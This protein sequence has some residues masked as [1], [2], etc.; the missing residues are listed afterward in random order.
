[1][2]CR[3]ERFAERFSSGGHRIERCLACGLVQLHPLPSPEV[4][5][6]L[7]GDHYYA[8]DGGT[9]YRD[10][11]AHEPGHRATFEAD[12]RRME[13]FFPAGRS[14]RVLDVGCGPGVFVTAALAAGHDAYGVDLVAS[15]V[16]H[17]QRR[18]PGRV[19]LG[20][21]EAAADLGGTPF[22]VV[23]ASHVIEHLAE[24]LAFTARCRE[25]LGPGGLLVCVTPNVR[26]WLARLSGRRWVS[27]KIPE[28]LAY[29]DPDTIRRL[30]TT[31]G[32]ETLAVDPAYE[33]HTVAFLAE[34]VRSLVRP[35]D[36]V[37]PPVERAPWLRD[38]VVRVTS[39]SLRAIARA[40]R[41]AS[42]P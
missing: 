16:E 5:A 35:L 23:F 10:Y 9:G 27:F 42:Q 28:H 32:F 2:L 22:D 33:H 6:A 3:G 14:L 1:M 29:Y 38:R 40:R 41:P 15:A 34:R 13:G 19:A 18:H 37:V 11:L 12:L 26:S 30:L 39:G 8:G 4:I 20:G 17:A 21:I 24:P 36:R 31:A 7:Y 25:L